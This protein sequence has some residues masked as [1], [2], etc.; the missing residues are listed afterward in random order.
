[1]RLGHGMVDGDKMLIFHGFHCD[2][3]V[4]IRRFRF[5]RRQSDTAAADQCI[6]GAVKDVAAEGANIK[7]TPQQIGGDVLIDDGLPVHQLD[8]GNAQS[9]RQRLQQRNIRQALSASQKPFAWAKLLQYSLA[10]MPPREKL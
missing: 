7:L 6:S 10:V 2:A 3:V 4:L 5:Q 8:D 1:M 9:F